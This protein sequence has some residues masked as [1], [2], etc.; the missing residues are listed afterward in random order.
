MPKSEVW[1]RILSLGTI[2][3]WPLAMPRSLLRMTG[4]KECVPVATLY[5]PILCTGSS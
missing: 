1:D 2:G 3:Y 4:M 5:V